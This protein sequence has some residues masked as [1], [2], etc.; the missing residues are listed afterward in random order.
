L[1]TPAPRPWWSRIIPTK[2]PP[3]DA[4]HW[5][6]LGLVLVGEITAQY[7]ASLLV[8]ALPQI[9]AG[10]SIPEAE[11]G[12]IGGSLRLGMVLTILVTALADRM[13]RRRMLLVSIALMCV[14]TAASGLARTGG[15]FLAV[16]LVARIFMGAVF[17]LG[18]VVIA[19]EFSANDRGWGIGALSMLGSVGYASGMGFYAAIDWMSSGWRILHFVCLAPLLVLPLLAQRMPETQRF[20][21]GAGA[22]KSAALVNSLWKTLSSP[23]LSLASGGRTRIIALSVFAFSF[24]MVGWPVLVLLSKHLQDQHSY[25][26]G[27]VSLVMLVGGL[28]GIIGNLAA[29]Q[30]SDRIGRR[31]VAVGMLALLT[32]GSVMMFQS[33]GL[34]III[35]WA[36]ASF[37]LTGGNVLLSALANEL[38]PTG[39]RSTA[40]GL[41]VSVASLGGAVGFYIEAAVYDGSHG[42]AVMWL[43]PALALA[44]V[45]IVFLPEAAGL[46]LED[47]AP[48]ARPES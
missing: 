45:A 4:G 7:A 14:A 11:V 18:T 15:E 36:G 12:S 23:F 16:Q 24:E 6:I 19:E 22:R 39:G 8:M 21:E 44:A 29:G 10:L 43:L 26:P 32:A 13:G 3:L 2:P 48:D 38:F 33:T 41:R 27:E 5:N 35:G 42:D 9:Q 37:A 46:E 30:W 17:M 31:P 20:S 34:W 40:A 25:A 28:V 47:A 1:T